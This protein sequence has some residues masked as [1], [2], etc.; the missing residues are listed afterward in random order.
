M[1]VPS[2]DGS[3]NGLRLE[4]RFEDFELTDEGIYR[5]VLV[6]GPL[7]ALALGVPP[8][9]FLISILIIATFPS[10]LVFIAASLLI[11]LSVASGAVFLPSLMRRRKGTPFREFTSCPGS[12]NRL[13]SRIV[14]SL[15]LFRRL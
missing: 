5:I 8:F 14:Q 2:D 7:K 15:E 6:S 4:G 13:Q 12:S 9:V 3:E 11:G 10:Q 1:V